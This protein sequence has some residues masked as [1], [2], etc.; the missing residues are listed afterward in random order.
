MTGGFDLGLEWA[1]MICKW[2]VENNPFCLKVLA[3]HW[4]NVKRCED[5]REVGKHNLESVDLICGGFPCQ[6][7]SVA[8]KRRG[9]EDD[10]YLWPEMLRVITELRPTWVI[11]ENVPGIINMELDK[12][13]SDLE[14]QGYETAPPLIIPAC[15]VD[16][17]HRR[18]RV[19]I[20]AYNAKQIDRSN[21]TKKSNGQ[22]QQSGKRIGKKNV[23][24]ASCEL[25]NRSGVA[26]KQRRQSTDGSSQDAPDADSKGLPTQ[27]KQEGIRKKERQACSGTQRASL[28]GRE[29]NSTRWLPEP[30]ICQLDDGLSPGLVRY[31]GRIATNIPNRV[32]KLTALG[33]AVVPQIVEIIGRIIIQVYKETINDKN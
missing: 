14:D 6:P 7:F 27:R 31:E 29:R 20:V 16:A 17:P 15:G 3:K 33:N 25:L 23:A 32:V 4:P 28:L 24:D 11:G 22:I 13:L 9:K 18:D 8:G 10:R 1:G 2:Q 19:W 12:T 26:R 21:N 5:V 30:A